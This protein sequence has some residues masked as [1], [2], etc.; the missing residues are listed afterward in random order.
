MDGV[1][2]QSERAEAPITSRDSQCSDL[3]DGVGGDGG[4]G[5]TEVAWRDGAGLYSR[6]TGRDMK[7]RLKVVP[8]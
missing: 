4:E 7:K 3:A 5:E 1:L 8:I 2:G 6:A